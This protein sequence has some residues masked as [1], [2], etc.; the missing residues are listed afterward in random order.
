MVQLKIQT[1]VGKLKIA[2]G[3][4]PSLSDCLGKGDIWASGLAI[5]GT[6]KCGVS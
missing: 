2:I 1:N 5:K 6:W 3:E 4:P